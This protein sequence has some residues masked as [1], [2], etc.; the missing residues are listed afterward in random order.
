MSYK[1]EVS[2]KRA[3]EGSRLFINSA[4][5]SPRYLSL[6]SAPPSQLDDSTGSLMINDSV[7]EQ[8]TGKNNK[9]AL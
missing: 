7:K 5:V 3:R 9:V 6:Y 2:Q 4:Q 8:N 1:I